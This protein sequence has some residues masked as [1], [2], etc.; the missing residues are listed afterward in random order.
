VRLT[1]SIITVNALNA[2]SP[3]VSISS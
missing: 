3:T 1:P 2:S